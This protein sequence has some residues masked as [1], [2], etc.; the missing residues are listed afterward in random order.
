MVALIDRNDAQEI[1][2]QIETDLD[3]SIDRI[4]IIWFNEE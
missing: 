3:R 4:I 2:A 1:R